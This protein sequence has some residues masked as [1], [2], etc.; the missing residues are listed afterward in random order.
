MSQIS[1]RSLMLGAAPISGGAQQV[2]AVFAV[3]QGSFAAPDPAGLASA[4]QSNNDRTLT[5]TGSVSQINTWLAAGKLRYAAGALAN[6]ASVDLQVSVTN[7]DALDDSGFARA[8][9]ARSRPAGE[10]IAVRPSRKPRRG[11]WRTLR[12]SPRGA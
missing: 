4:T 2:S 3:Q 12:R 1:R 6:G 11:R 8:A 7:V 9:A 5:L 10:S